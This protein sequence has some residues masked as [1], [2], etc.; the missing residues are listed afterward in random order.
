MRGRKRGWER[1]KIAQRNKSGPR[2][3]GRE[4]EREAGEGDVEK[5]RD[6]KRP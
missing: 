4:R 3:N 1:S 2:G 5:E 6:P